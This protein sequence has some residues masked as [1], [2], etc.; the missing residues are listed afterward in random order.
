MPDRV[1][2]PNN[3]EYNGASP[4]ILALAKTTLD[5][6]A[7]K[8]ADGQQIIPFTALAVKENLFI[9]THEYPTEEETYEAARAEVQGARGATGYAFC[10]Q[11][12]LSTNK[13]PVDCLISECGLPGEDTAMGFGYLYDDEGIYRDEVTY[14]GPAPN[15]MSR[16]KEEPEIE[17]ELN[18]ST[19]EVKVQGMFNADDA[20]ARM[21]AAL[22]KAEAE[23]KTN[24]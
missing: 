6:A 5:E 4:V 1:V 19:G 7:D 22:E 13:G 17:A 14:L 3:N 10:Y 11:G 16:L 2:D 9:E 21:E 12:S 8:L 18:K 23:G 24:L 15:Y 20:V